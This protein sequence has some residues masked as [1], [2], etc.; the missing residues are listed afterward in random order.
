MASGTLRGS[1]EGCYS[2]RIKCP[3]ASRAGWLW[4]LQA[5]ACHAPRSDAENGP[6]WSAACRNDQ[7]FGGSA[8]LCSTAHSAA[9]VRDA[10]PS[11]PRM[12]DT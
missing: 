11:L 3:A 6:Q 1:A 9:C 4:A 12:L 5:G 8:S 2:T 10:R 7:A